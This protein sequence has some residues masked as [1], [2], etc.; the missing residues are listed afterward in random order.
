MHNACGRPGN[1]QWLSSKRMGLS[2]MM[3]AQVV[4][5]KHKGWGEGIETLCLCFLLMT[6]FAAE[7]LLV[8]NMLFYCIFVTSPFLVRFVYGFEIWRTLVWFWYLWPQP[9]SFIML[10]TYNSMR[11]WMRRDWYSWWRL[12]LLIITY[13]YGSC[14]FSIFRY[15]G[16]K[17]HCPM[18][19]RCCVYYSLCFCSFFL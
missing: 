13:P 8:C 3:P 11:S 5:L 9:C 17:L 16:S 14:L 7:W 1:H 4:L 10:W 18:I 12:V 6:S 15:F 2:I 19:L